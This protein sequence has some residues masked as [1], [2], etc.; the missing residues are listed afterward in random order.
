MAQKR[1]LGFSPNTEGG[2]SF[3]SPN[4]TDAEVADLLARVLE[5]AGHEVSGGYHFD[6][7]IEALRL[8]AIEALANYRAGVARDA[9]VERDV[10]RKAL[11]LYEVFDDA[12]EEKTHWDD[13]R[14]DVQEG[15]IAV[16]RH[17]LGARA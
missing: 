1:I 8:D 7:S 6:A 3:T 13:A 14:E 15:F 5:A 16:A 9:E 11:E 4:P 10:E 12:Q 2:G 17:E